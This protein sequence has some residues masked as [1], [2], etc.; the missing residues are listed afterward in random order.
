MTSTQEVAATKAFV[1]ETQ[2][3]ERVG[4]IRK[5][6]AQLAQDLHSF[7]KG[8]CWEALGYETLEQWL[9]SPH[10]EIGRR[11]FFL[12]VDTFRQL[13]LSEKM[14]LE[15]LGH[16]DITKVQAVLPAIR[17]GQ[18][19]I[20]EALGD[21]AEL[22]LRALREKY[23][24]LRPLDAGPDRSI[25]PDEFHYEKCSMCGSTLKLDDANII[26]GVRP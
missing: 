14:T 17:R 15:A 8:Q 4:A 19:E 5:E 26:R 20:G 23:T 11:M 2:I 7:H 12:L 13:V 25:K 16:V 3:V 10:I 9:A 21:V 6:W 24:D 22:P 18:V 1:L